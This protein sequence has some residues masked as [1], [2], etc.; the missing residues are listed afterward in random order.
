MKTLLALTLAVL[1][2]EQACA[3]ALACPKRSP[4]PLGKPQ[5]RLSGVQVLAW[6]IAQPLPPDSAPPILAPYEART[7]GRLLHQYWNMNVSPDNDDRVEC[8]YGG[9]ERVLR[10]DANSVK[11]CELIGRE[12]GATV[13]DPELPLQIEAWRSP[14]AAA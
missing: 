5:T 13:R 8:R 7:I 2:A 11:R 3:Q 9:A 1:M 6:P 10:L 12:K 4:T 14:P